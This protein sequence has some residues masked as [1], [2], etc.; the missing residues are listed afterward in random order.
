[1]KTEN[2]GGRRVKID[3][4]LTGTPTFITWFSMKGRC[5]NPNNPGFKNYGGRGIKVCKRWLDFGN[6]CTDMGARPEGMTLDR[7]NNDKNYNK[8]NCKWSTIEEQNNNKRD[9]RLYEYKGKTFS[10][11]RWSRELGINAYTLY[12]RLDKG[13]SFEE[14]ATMPLQVNKSC[15]L[16]NKE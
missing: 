16:R 4:P 1:M 7:K 3:H 15:Y 9:T 11:A 14:A 10:I 5:L 13:M 8:S 12:S 6:F 2:R